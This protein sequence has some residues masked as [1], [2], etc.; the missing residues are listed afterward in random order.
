M[1]DSSRRNNIRFCLQIVVIVL[2]VLTGLLISLPFTARVDGVGPPQ[3]SM[4]NLHI[5]GL[6]F[7][8][9]HQD[10]GSFPLQAI[11]NKRGEPLLSWRV[12]LLPYLEE[13]ELYSQFHLDEPWDSPNNESLLARIPPV[14]A[15]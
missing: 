4:N 13:Q 12:A 5:I 7:Y 14:Y 11:Y 15:S 3:Q 8:C 6:A 2:I 10:H 1:A 9:Y